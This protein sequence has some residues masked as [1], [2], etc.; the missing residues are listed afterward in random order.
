M[1]EQVEQSEYKQG[2]PITIHSFDDTGVTYR[3]EIVGIASRHPGVV[4]YIVKLIDKV[5]G[6]EYECLT[7]IS[8]CIKERVEK[9]DKVI[10]VTITNVEFYTTDSGLDK[11]CCTNLAKI[12]G[13]RIRKM[14]PG[15]AINCIVTSTKGYADYWRVISREEQ[16]QQ[17]C[18]E[19]LHK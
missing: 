13:S 11:K 16:F 15:T 14:F 3:G 8:S 4:F 1:T 17:E 10:H 12:V 2:T 7:V 19:G 5:P 9:N 6:N 18:A